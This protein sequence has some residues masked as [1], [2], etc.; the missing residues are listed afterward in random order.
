MCVSRA[1]DEEDGGP[2]AGVQD[3]QEVCTTSFSTSPPSQVGQHTPW[4]LFTV[5]LLNDFSSFSHLF[6]TSLSLSLFLFV[7]FLSSCPFY[8][9]NLCVRLHYL[10]VC[11]HW[12]RLPLNCLSPF[13]WTV[14]SFHWLLDLSL[15]LWV[16]TGHCESVTVCETPWNWKLFLICFGV[17]A[18]LWCVRAA[19]QTC[20]Y[21]HL[22]WLCS[23]IHHLLQHRA[24]C[25]I[26]LV[27]C[28]CCS[29][30]ELFYH[31]H[32]Q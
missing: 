5:S 4:L 7:C 30:L 14:C 19:S 17:C 9:V 1:P 6:F 28:K 15:T 2:F 18:A 20:F 27:S 31:L 26:V 3:S 21:H 16:Y 29:S 23:K 8:C 11:V 24:F 13:P 25:I 10:S 32:P 22:F 12:V